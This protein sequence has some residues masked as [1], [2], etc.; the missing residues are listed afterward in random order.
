M[1]KV[2]SLMILVL[3]VFVFS[4]VVLA[5]SDSAGT[6]TGTGTG[7]VAPKISAS[8]TTGS[9][10]A[11][12]N[13]VKTQ[14]A[15]EESQLM[16]STAEQESAGDSTISAGMRSEM[17]IEKMSE[18]A[19]NVEILLMD[20]TLT[21]GIGQQVKAIAQEQKNS[22]DKVQNQIKSIDSRGGFVKALIGPDYQTLKE[23][24]MQLDQNQLRIEALTELKNQLTN[25]GDITMVEETIKLLAEENIGLQDKINAENRV[26]SVFGWLIK[27]FV[28]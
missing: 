28:K 1:K 27:L 13:Q 18:V 20:K 10:V 17:A 3:L 26:G 12:Q 11:N 9:G 24:E 7:A 5:K 4:S 23:L 16:I 21:G 6:G 2:T 8:P 14:N 25:A 19:K 22:M 15:G